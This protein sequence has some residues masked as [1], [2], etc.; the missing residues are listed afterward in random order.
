MHDRMWS[1]RKYSLRASSCLLGLS[2]IPICSLL[3]SLYSRTMASSSSSNPPLPAECV[4]E[5]IEKASITPKF[6]HQ[7]WH[8]HPWQWPPHC[9]HRQGALVYFPTQQLSS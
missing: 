9:S 3:P 8:S 4:A 5:I 6:D 7:D 2:I 1:P